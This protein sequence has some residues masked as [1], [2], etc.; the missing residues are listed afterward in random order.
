M[1]CNRGPSDCPS[2]EVVA[3]ASS[4]PLGRTFAAI[5]AWVWAVV[6]VGARV[7]E[8]LLAVVVAAFVAQWYF[9][10]ILHVIAAD[11]VDS[12]VVVRVIHIALVVVLVDVVSRCFH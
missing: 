5:G 6:A 1:G 7:V 12:A 11:V 8:T 2:H 3:A 4:V 9:V 10:T